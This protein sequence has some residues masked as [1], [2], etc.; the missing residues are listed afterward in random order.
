MQRRK[1]DGGR[2]TDADVLRS[3]A[4]SHPFVSLIVTVKNE[5]H[6]IARLLNSI[7]AQ[8]RLPDEVVIADGGSRDETVQLIEAWGARQSFPVRVLVMPDA[9]I[10]QGRNAA[11]RVARGEVI[12]ATD[13]GVRLD[14]CW[15]E[16]LIAPFETTSDVW[17]VTSAHVVSPVT[18]HLSPQVVSGFFIPD[19]HNAFET[20][21][22]ATVLP[23]L[24]D[25]KPETF[26]PS[27]RSVAFTKDAWQAVGGYPEWL[28]YCEDLVF[29]LSL[30]EMFTFGFAPDAVVYFR[31]RGSLRAFF[32]QYY[33]YARGDGK[34]DLWRKR[35]AIR[36]VTYLI[37]APLLL[38]LT[39]KHSHWWLGALGVG[40]ALYTRAPYRRLAPDLARMSLRDKLYALALVSIIRVVGDA[41]KMLGYPVGVVWRRRQVSGIKC[42][43]SRDVRLDT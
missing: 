6:V 30:R 13:A 42:Q 35:H 9:N 21:M 43:V 18:C 26:L 27:S 22:S 29:D 11:I 20:A 5:A 39:L 10:S 24:R 19:P 8:T 31:P 34:A 41:A 15:L 36:Y 37:A 14:E 17:Q 4:P 40:A 28:D 7:S 2:K 12:A 3:V 16:K 32:K 25:V 23:H 38:V 1:A 33:L